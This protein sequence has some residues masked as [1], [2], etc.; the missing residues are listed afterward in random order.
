[1]LEAFEVAWIFTS[2]C[3]REGRLMAKAVVGWR[4]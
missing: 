4:K 3:L 2:A 1:M